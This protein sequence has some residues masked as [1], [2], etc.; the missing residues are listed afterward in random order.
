MEGGGWE[1][2][3][4]RVLKLEQSLHTMKV[5]IVSSMVCAVF[6]LIVEKPMKVEEKNRNEEK[7]CFY[8]SN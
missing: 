8:E 7:K 2:R 3:W 4:G 5:G 6:Y 1:V